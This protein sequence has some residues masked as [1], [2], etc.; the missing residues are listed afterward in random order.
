MKNAYENMYDNN[1][2]NSDYSFYKNGTGLFPW[3]ITDNGD[4]LFWNYLNGETEII[5]FASRY[6]DVIS[7]KMNMIDFLVGVLTKKIECDIFPDD[8]VLKDNLY[9]SV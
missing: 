2:V 1:L 4:E 6:T 7:Y 3:G 9:N 5:V 8:F